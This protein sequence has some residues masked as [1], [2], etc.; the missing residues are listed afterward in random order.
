MLFFVLVLILPSFVFFGIQGYNQMLDGDRAVARV[1]GK[2]ITQPEFDDAQRRFFDQLRNQYGQS[3]DPKIMDTPRAR[4]GVLERLMNEKVLLAEAA[5][6][7]VIYSDAKLAEF[8][9]STPEF[10]DNGV[11]SP[12]KKTEVAIRL[13]LTGVGLDQL[14]R[15]EQ[16]S[17]LLRSGVNE[18]GIV[19]ASVRDRLLALSEEQREVRERRFKPEDFARQVVIDDDAVNAHYEANPRLYET[20]ETIAVAY[21]VLTLDAIAAQVNVSDSDLRRQYDTSFGA[22]LKRRDEVR[23]RAEALH[24]QVRKTPASFAELAKRHSEDPGSAAQGG[25]LPAFGR[26]EMVKPF[27][28]AAFRLRKGE[29]A[30]TLVETEFGFHIMQLDDIQRG[31]QDKGGERRVARHILL[32]APEA[33]RFEEV[34]ADLEKSAKQQEAQRKF[35]E[36][37]DTFNNTV[38]EQPDSLAPVAEKLKLP[39]QRAEGV[40]RGAVSGRADGAQALTPKVIEALFT[41]DAIKNKRNTQAIETA[42]GTL[43]AARVLDHKPAALRPLDSVRAEIRAKLARDE[44]SRLAREAAMK[45][46]AELRSAPSDSGFAAAKK[47]SRAQPDGMALEALKAV[48]APA[49]SSLPTFVMSPAGG[50][51]YAVYQV[52]S[53]KSAGAPDAARL[54]SATRSLAQ[55]S[56]AADDI[57]YVATLRDVHDAQ[58]LKAEYRL[59]APAPIES[60]KR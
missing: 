41:D 20:P 46:L 55:Q 25:V 49:A 60:A 40:T 56:G 26:G 17:L 45:K 39:V 44:A 4:A 42:P 18:T 24:A 47:V 35:V 9:S 14:I 48:M 3:L 7:H 1:A 36:A 30:P 22:N 31:G 51:A 59:P 6:A 52:L 10:L 8:Y 16:A 23:A 38:Y 37:A 19:P 43:V 57:A 53:S 29:L 58:V 50:G 28:D 32:S 34:R 2:S 54:M 12:E 5:R 13:G 33:R 15:R 27:E 21:V 11:F